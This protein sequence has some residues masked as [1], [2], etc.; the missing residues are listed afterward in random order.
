MSTPKN[1]QSPH[2]GPRL[3]EWT[4][5]VR[6]QPAQARERILESYRACGGH[7][8]Q[9]AVQLALPARSLV[10]YVDRLGLAADI[11]LIRNRPKTH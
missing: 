4:Y 1:P 9:A 8:G 3:T 10:R 2:A 11:A 7:A 6:F 5:L